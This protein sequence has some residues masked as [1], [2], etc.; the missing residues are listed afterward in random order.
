[1]VRCDL[2]ILQSPWI[3]VQE[4]HVETVVSAIREKNIEL[5]IF[6]GSEDGDVW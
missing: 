3:P 4:E 5:R 6:C 1:M 2:L